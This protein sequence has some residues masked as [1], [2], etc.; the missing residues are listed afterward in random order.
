MV[1]PF[2][3][4]KDRHHTPGEHYTIPDKS[5]IIHTFVLNLGFF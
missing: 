4:L 3:R 5:Y 1:I 2:S